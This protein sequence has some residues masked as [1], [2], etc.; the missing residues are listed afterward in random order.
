MG[1]KQNREEQIRF[2]GTTSG[3]EKPSSYTFDPEAFLRSR[4]Q[5]QWQVQ[6]FAWVTQCWLYEVDHIP[7]TAEEL[8]NFDMKGL[9]AEFEKKFIAGDWKKMVPESGATTDE[10]VLAFQLFTK[11]PAMM[12]FNGGQ[13][14]P[15]LLPELARHQFVPASVMTATIL[16]FVNGPQGPYTP[17]LTTDGSDYHSFNIM[18]YF[19]DREVLRYMDDIGE[20]GKCFLS[21]GYNQLDIDS[22]FIETTP[23]NHWL[24]EVDIKDFSRVFYGIQLHLGRY[25]HW[26][27]A[28]AKNGGVEYLV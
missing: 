21:K 13:E 2:G 1:L 28:L 4:T 19:P 10:S 5:V 22:K 11:E 17:V 27:D 25:K 7:N 8:A 6:L 14:P 16:D 24:W 20:N 23:D 26:N 18:Q 12:I 9:I 3:G 15:S